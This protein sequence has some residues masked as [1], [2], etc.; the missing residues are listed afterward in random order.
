MATNY[1][2]IDNLY[3]SRITLLEYLAEQGYDTAPYLKFSP[4]E[5]EEMFKAAPGNQ[6]SPVLQMELKRTIPDPETLVETCIV[7][8][9]LGKIKQKLMVANSFIAL[10][11]EGKSQEYFTKT[12]FIVL[13][14]EEISPQSSFDLAAAD[15][16]NKYKMRIRFFS[17]PRLITNPLKHVLV[18]KHE[19][20]PHVE[21]EKLMKELYAKKKELPL[22]RFHE[23]PIAKWIGLVPGDIV[24][25]T[26]PSP[27]AGETIYY[28]LCVA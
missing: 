25:I 24:K 2:I 21:H 1:E 5:I 4:K 6:F 13:T 20:V 15:S 22:I 17:I 16:W 26:R 28:R 23:D 11:A 10:M 27:S 9:S 12:E 3:R 18:P 14:H 7:M 8:Y 19:R